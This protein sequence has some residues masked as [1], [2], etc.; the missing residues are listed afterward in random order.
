MHPH[1]PAYTHYT[2]VGASRIDRI[3]ITNPLQRRKQGLETVAVAF[4]DHFSVIIRMTVGGISMLQKARVWRINT[5]L[6]EEP[7]F[8]EIIKEQWGKW[9]KKIG[10]YANK[11]MWWDK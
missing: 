11:V 7:S 6:L 9:Q 10:Y 1:I 3:Y 5:T 2:N 8:R 4:S